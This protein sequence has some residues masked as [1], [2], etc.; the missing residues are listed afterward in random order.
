MLKPRQVSQSQTGNESACA[1]RRTRKIQRPRHQV[2]AQIPHAPLSEPGTGRG[3]SSSTSCSSHRRTSSSQPS[4]VARTRTDRPLHPRVGQPPNS[5]AQA[6]WQTVWQWGH[7]TK[8]SPAS[9]S[10]HSGQCCS[11]PSRTRRLGRSAIQAHSPWAIR[12]MEHPQQA[13][14]VG[15]TVNLAARA[16]VGL[17][18]PE[19][20]S[21]CMPDYG[22]AVALES[23]QRREGE[24]EVSSVPQRDRLVV[25]GQVAGGGRS[26]GVR[27]QFAHSQYLMW[28]VGMFYSGKYLLFG[29]L[30]A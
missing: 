1:P 18:G 20:G 21:R 11:A 30:A 27:S 17:R 29:I 10:R 12:Y 15:T 8:S 6:S 9:P 23:R 5:T 24:R 19:V 2:T 13:A 28:Y 16:V 4:S 22:N 7:T 14:R 26:L 3:V 25:L